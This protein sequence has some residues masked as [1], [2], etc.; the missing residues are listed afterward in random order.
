MIL[1]TDKVLFT[2]LLASSV[3]HLCALLWGERDVF[4][5][6][7][8]ECFLGR[9]LF[10]RNFGVPFKRRVRN[11]AILNCFLRV[12]SSHLCLLVII[13]PQ[14][15]YLSNLIIKKKNWMKSR[16]ACWQLGS[17]KFLIIILMSNK[18]K[19]KARN[20]AKR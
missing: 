10:I 4:I 20:P 17:F 1:T 19:A 15:I 6:L 7:S 11:L 16:Y 9:R 8:Q 14:E 12:N 3:C 13:M 2:N 5:L 18:A